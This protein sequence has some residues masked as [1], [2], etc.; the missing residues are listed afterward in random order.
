M[1]TSMVDVR[2]IV[3][4]SVHQNSSRG[5]DYVAGLMVLAR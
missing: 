3:G 1:F 2:K 5:A 4:A